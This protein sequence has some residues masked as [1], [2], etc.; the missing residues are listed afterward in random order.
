MAP[1][2]A[3]LVVAVAL[4]ACGKKPGKLKPADGKTTT[5]PRDYPTS[6]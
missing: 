4:A 5:Y 2:A 1:F 6:K 3:V